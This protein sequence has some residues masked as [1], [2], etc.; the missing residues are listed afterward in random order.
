MVDNVNNNVKPTEVVVK[1]GGP[2]CNPGIKPQN[3]SNLLNSIISTD[4]NNDGGVSRQEL[5]YMGSMLSQRLNHLKMMKQFFPYWGGYFDQ[6][7][8]Q[9]QQ[10]LDSLTVVHNNWDAFSGAGHNS[11]IDGQDIMNIVKAA[12]TDGKVNDFTQ[13]DLNEL[14][15]D[16]PPPIMPMYAAL[17]CSS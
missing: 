15:N 6:Y 10:K 17:D 5:N 4:I 7:I 3:T 8:E 1:Y 13:Q 16:G 11:V 2:D 12:G 9:Y 14:K